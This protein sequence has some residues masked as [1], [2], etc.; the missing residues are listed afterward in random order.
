MASDD[1]TS[2]AAAQLAAQVAD[3]AAQQE[4]VRM[5]LYLLEIPEMQQQ[6]LEEQ[7]RIAFEWSQFAWQTAFQ[8][9]SL[10]G[11]I[12]AGGLQMQLPNV[13]TLRAMTGVTSPATGSGGTST[14][15]AGG[16][17][18]TFNGP[19]SGGSW[20]AVEQAIAAKGL[21]GVG[22]GI[23]MDAMDQ[24]VFDQ[25]LNALKAT[26]S[27]P[28]DPRIAPIISAV[29]AAGGNIS[30]YQDWL[31]TGQSAGGGPVSPFTP[32][33]GTGF[34]GGPPVDGQPNATVDLQLPGL[35][36]GETPT[37]EYI[38]TLANLTGQIA[39]NPTLEAQI[40]Q[41]NV[42]GM[43]SLQA[44][45]L[46]G[47]VSPVMQWRGSGPWGAE[48]WYDQYGNPIQLAS[49]GGTPGTQPYGMVPTLERE[50]EYNQRAVQ[51][52]QLAA[53]LRQDPFR[54][55]MTLGQTPNG[56]VD[57]FNAAA[58]QL[59]LPGY[60]A[61]QPGSYPTLDQFVGD[62]QSMLPGGAQQPMQYAPPGTQAAQN[63]YNYEPSQGG[64][65]NVYPPGT[66]APENRM[67]VSTSAPSYSQAIQQALASTPYVA[68]SQISPQA[69]NDMQPTQR[70]LLFKSY[71]LYGLEPEAAEAAYKASLPKYAGSNPVGRVQIENR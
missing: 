67:Q 17:S 69:V 18:F 30:A 65:L 10:T 11:K 32:L 62:V 70:D 47:Y 15:G 26:G 53:S 34:S 22:S 54:M 20:D 52:L 33:P 12:P 38:Q 66:T 50:S 8:T 43:P 27:A 41:G 39:G 68:P 23:N 31:R 35:A 2:I 25:W 29:Q 7:D 42:G 14:P 21:S 51:L 3:N 60:S 56:L 55:A 61:G 16:G 36:P 6:S 37:L 19:T 44:Q 57:I 45:Q 64:T 59:N 4:Y 49:E 48:G 63:A 5:R 28:D 13:Q 24:G 58:G 9:A 71:Q 1:L 40:A 46:A